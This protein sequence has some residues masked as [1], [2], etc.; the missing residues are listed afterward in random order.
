MVVGGSVWRRVYA[1]G[2][3]LNLEE[4]FG[5][6]PPNRAAYVSCALCAPAGLSPEER[7]L[8]LASGSDNGMALWVNGK[9]V[10]YQETASP[11]HEQSV[12]ADVELR[13]G[14]N[15]V[16][17][18]ASQAGGEW[19]VSLRVTKQDDTVPDWLRVRAQAPSA[20]PEIDR[21]GWQATASHNA[22]GV[23]LAFD[24]APATRWSS[25]TLM[26]PGMWFQLD[27]GRVVE[28]ARVLMDAGDFP[29]D[30]PRGYNLLASE[31]GE[32]WRVA[33]GDERASEHQAAGRLY[34]TLE[35]ALRA[36]YLKIVQ[37]GRD[38]RHFWSISELKVFA[39]GPQEQ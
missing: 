36:R 25:A 10:A 5:A 19:T 39:P 1:R 18:K 31:D 23:P 24:S 27:M 16:L 14:W 34:V 30:Y 17:A 11:A 7:R 38:D 21:H 15:V 20:L 13:E 2:Q 37:T 22:A 6:T 35:P 12:A 28:V 3:S 8:R 32:H 29:E 26:Q 4:I 9:R 33:G